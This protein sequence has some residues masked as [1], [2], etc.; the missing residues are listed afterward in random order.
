MYKSFRLWTALK[1]S[2]CS[3]WWTVIG[4]SALFFD[5]CLTAIKNSFEL[6]TYWEDFFQY[7]DT[8]SN[9]T[10]TLNASSIKKDDTCEYPLITHE[11]SL[12]VLIFFWL[13]TS[14]QLLPQFQIPAISVWDTI[15]YICNCKTIFWIFKACVCYFSLFLKDKCIS[16]LVRT[17]YIEKKFTFHC[18]TNIYSLLGYHALPAS[19]KLLV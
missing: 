13:F 11:D 19:L 17:K 12:S 3:F 16:S 6:D 2:V 4:K 9:Y 8:F 10:F 1:L 15:M 7:L 5:L 18:F 14:N